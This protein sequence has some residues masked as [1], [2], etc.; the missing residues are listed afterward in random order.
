MQLNSLLEYL[1]ILEIV[2]DDKKVWI[3]EKLFYKVKELLR[4]IANFTT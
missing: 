3:L 2:Y 1:D 4:I